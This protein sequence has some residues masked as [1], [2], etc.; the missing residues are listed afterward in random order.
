MERFVTC[1]IG[2]ICKVL[3]RSMIKIAAV[4]GTS[5]HRN[6]QVYNKNDSYIFHIWGYVKSIC[7]FPCLY[8]LTSAGFP[9][10]YQGV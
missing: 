8:F 3:C 1:E 10:T 6:T 7:L 4:K 2:S 9:R 5:I